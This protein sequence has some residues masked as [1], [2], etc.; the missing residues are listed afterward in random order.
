MGGFWRPRKRWVS[1]IRVARAPH[2]GQLNH[3]CVRLLRDHRLGILDL[4]ADLAVPPVHCG[5]DESRG[6]RSWMPGEPSTVPHHNRHKR[7]GC[8]TH[9]KRPYPAPRGSCSASQTPPDWKRSVNEGW[10]CYG[11]RPSPGHACPP[12]Q[13]PLLHLGSPGLLLKLLKRPLK[14]LEL[15]DHVGLERIASNGTPP[16]R[17]HLQPR[18]HGASGGAIE[19]PMLCTGFANGKASQSRRNRAACKVGGRQK[20]DLAR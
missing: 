2:L 1:V 12:R 16:H 18:S 10:V 17:H 8:S 7:W 13:P 4:L 5:G 6:G 19:Q 15:G 14:R 11:R 20:T 9:P 3:L